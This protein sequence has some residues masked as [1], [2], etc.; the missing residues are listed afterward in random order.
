MAALTL[1]IADKAHTLGVLT[2]LID[3]GAAITETGVEF[4]SGDKLTIT[5]L[6]KYD[7]ISL[8]TSGAASGDVQLVGTDIQ[9]H[10]GTGF[11]KIGTLDRA[12]DGTLIIEFVNTYLGT[13]VT[14][15][16]VEK[17]MQNLTIAADTS[18][19]I[20][21][22]R[23][24]TFTLSGSNTGSDTST[25]TIAGTTGAD[26]IIYSTNAATLSWTDGNAADGDILKVLVDQTVT[27]S[28]IDM[29]ATAY[30]VLEA[31]THN[32]ALTVTVGANNT[33]ITT[34][35]ANDIIK[36]SAAADLDT[37]IN[38]GLGVDTLELTNAGAITV[39]FGA[40][41]GT[42]ANIEKLQLAN[43]A[44]T[45]TLD[46]AD[47][48]KEI[49]GG[50]AVDIIDASDRAVTGAGTGQYDLKISTGAGADVVT[51]SKG[52][53]NIDLGTDDNELIITL[54]TD[55]TKDDV[56]T[57]AGAADKI[58]LDDAITTMTDEQFTGVT[59]FEELV[60]GTGAT[61]LTL[62]DQVREA[63]I[64]KVTGNAASHVVTGMLTVD[65]VGMTA[66]VGMTVLSG[67]GGVTIVTRADHVTTADTF[68]GDATV[69][70]DILR[71]ATSGTIDAADL[72]NVSNIETLDI[73]ATSGNVSVTI[74]EANNFKTISSTGSTGH[75][76]INTVAE[77]NVV[78]G[79]TINTGIGNDTITTGATT[80]GV[81][82]NAG[83]GDNI[84]TVGVATN[85]ITAGTGDDIVNLVAGTDTLKLG[86]GENIV[87]VAYANFTTADTIHYGDV[88]GSTVID[89]A[90][91]TAGIAAG[92]KNILNF[93]DKITDDGVAD[94]DGDQVEEKLAATGN[95]ID[96]IK[97][98]I[99]DTQIVTLG[100]NALAS[101]VI[102]VDGSL[103]TTNTNTL[104]V[105][106]TAMDPTSGTFTVKGGAGNDVVK[107]DFASVTSTTSLQMGGEAASG[108]DT[109]QIA[110][111]T[112]TGAT[113]EDADFTLST[114]LEKL[115]FAV[116]G[117][118][119]IT[120]GDKAINA[121]VRT[122]D[123]SMTVEAV[124]VAQL[125]ASTIDLSTATVDADFTI[126]MG[127][128]AD[129]IK[130]KA[131]HLTATDT[132]DGGL[133]SDTL[134]FVGASVLVDADFAGLTSVEKLKLG[135]GN[136][137]SLVYATNMQTAGI[138]LIDGSLVGAG[139]SVS[140]DLSAAT[141]GID[142][143]LSSGNDT[144]IMG[145]SALT[146]DLGDGNNTVQTDSAYLT[147]GDKI[148]GGTG[149]D[150]L[151]ITD[152]ATI[153]DLDFNQITN[154]EKLVL[155]DDVNSVELGAKAK[156][157]GVVTIDGS[158]STDVLTATVTD[159]GFNITGG[160][161]ADIIKID[162]ANLSSLTF[163]GMGGT[164]VIELTS[165][166]NLNDS[167]FA[168]LSQIETL[169]LNDFNTTQSITLGS[170]SVTADDAT[171]SGLTTI[172]ASG[173]LGVNNVEVD[174][175]GMLKNM[176]VTT[177][178]GNDIITM[179]RGVDT[180][181]TGLG[182][183]IIKV[184]SENFT[185]ADTIN[186]GG[187]TGAGGILGDILEITTTTNA[188]TD[189]H[190][191]N[192]LG[193]ET[194]KLSSASGTYDITLG[195]TEA[196]ANGIREIAIA[197]GVSAN[198]DLSTITGG[199]IKITKIGTTGNVTVTTSTTNQ[200][201]N[202]V[203]GNGA[204]TVKI[205][206][207]NLTNADTY[208]FGAGAD[209]LELT[210]AATVIDADFAN[211]TGVETV[212]VGNFANSITIGDTASTTG[213]VTTVDL[214][215]VTT[216]TNA[217]TVD[218]STMLNNVG[219]TVT[220]GAGVDTIKM[221]AE[222]LTTADHLI[223][224]GSTDI[225]QFTTL[226]VG[227]TDTDF[228]NVT[229][230]ETLKLV[231]G[232]TGDTQSLSL[233]TQAFDG[234]N[235]LKTI[236]GSSVAG[237]LTV[238]LT[239][240]SDV[241]ITG[242]KVD[243]TNDGTTTTPRDI[244]INDVVYDQPNDLYYKAKVANGTANLT[245]EDFT[246]GANWE[247][248][249]FTPELV[250]TMD[251]AYLTSADTI[252]GG[253]STTDKIIFDTAAT[254]VGATA[255]TGVSGIE[256]LELKATS[257][258]QS[259]TLGGSGITTVDATLAGAAVTIDGATTTGINLS[260]VITNT[261]NDTLKI[262]AGDLDAGDIFT[263][264]SG[265]NTLEITTDATNTITDSDFAN[266]TGINTLKLSKDVTGQT[267]TLANTAITAGV[268]KVDL[269]S[270]TSAS[271]S[272]VDLSTMTTENV[273]FT[274]LGGSGA[275][276]I[277]M[278]AAQLASTDVLT[279][280]GGTDTLEFT[281]IADGM[282][283]TQFTGVTGIDTLK[284]A[285][286][287]GQ[288]ITLGTKALEVGNIRTIDGSNLTGINT[289]TISD[290][291]TNHG[292]T[293]TTG[294]G[295]DTIVM[296]AEDLTSS[297]TINGNGGTDTLS[298]SA[299]GAD[300]TIG[301]A[302][303]T[304][305]SNVEILKLQ[306]SGSFTQ[307]VTLGGGFTTVDAS[308]ATD[309][310]TIDGYTTTALN[311]ASV[312]TGTGADTLKIKAADL[313]A[314]DVFA[315]GTG[316]DT[317]QIMTD[318][319]SLITDAKFTNKTE[320]DTLK[321]GNFTGQTL[322]IGD[323]AVTAGI[324][325]IDL[326]GITSSGN[327]STV[328]M[329]TNMNLAKDMIVLGGA[330]ADT[331]QMKTEHLTLSDT[332]TGNGGDDVLELTTVATNVTDA[333]FTEVTGIETLKLG[334]FTNQSLTLGNEALGGGIRI[335]N[336]TALD[337][338]NGVSI[339]MSGATNDYA[340]TINTGT[341][342]GAD[343]V[344]MKAEHL[345]SADTIA[346]G[347]GTADKLTLTT[348]TG[349]LGASSFGNI[350]G[351]EV[352]ELTATTGAQNITL[353]GDF[354]TVDAHTTDTAITIDGAT[355][356][357]L[358]LSNVTTGS[359]NDTLKIQAS[360]FTKD[361]AGTGGVDESDIFA[362][363]DGA[364]TL[365]LVGA[366]TITD[367]QFKKVT[368][369]E[370]VT[371]LANATGQSV[372]LGDLSVAAGL[373]KVDFSAITNTTFGVTV[374]LDDITSDSTS[375]II[376][377]AGADSIIMNASHLTIADTLTG[378]GNGSGV[379]TLTLVGA[380]TLLDADFTNVS[381]I[382]KLVLANADGQTLQLG[383]EALGGGITTVDG[384]ALSLH[385]VAIDMSGASLN[386]D[387]TITT[388]TGADTITMLA[389]HLTSADTLNGGTGVAVDTLAFTDA[390]N[391][392]ADKF[393]HVTNMEKI[394]LQATT[395][396]QDIA[397]VSGFNTVDASVATDSVTID[398]SL[399]GD[400]N[401]T[402]TTGTDND[403][404]KLT[405]TTLDTNDTI[406]G[407]STSDT[408]T[409]EIIA[410]G[411]TD[412][413]ASTLDNE[414]TD[415]KIAHVTNVE[416]I[417]LTNSLDAVN[418]TLGSN[419]STN[420]INK[421]DASAT[422][423]VN[424]IDLS[425]MTTNVEVTGGTGSDII[426]ASIGDNVINAGYGNDTVTINAGNLDASDIIDG[427]DGIDE[428]ILTGLTTDTAT[429]AGITGFESI[430]LADGV[431]QE[432]ILGAAEDLNNLLKVDA[433]NVTTGNAITVDITGYEIVT[434]VDNFTYVGGAGDD[435]FKMQSTHLTK[436]DVLSGGFIDVNTDGIDDSTDILEFTDVAI[437]S[438]SIDIFNNVS[439]FET[440]KLADVAS[441]QLVT[442]KDGV[443]TTVTAAGNTSTDA[444]T[445]NAGN[446]TGNL[447]I[448]TVGGADIIT[449]AKG[450]NTISSG[451]GADTI[452]FNI[453]TFTSADVI[454]G[455]DDT[456][457]I[458]FID[459]SVSGA[460][461]LTDAAFAGGNKTNI[462]KIK[463]SVNEAGQSI[464]LGTDATS[465]GINEIDT[466]T[467]LQTVTIDAGALGNNLT[468]NTN[469]GND[470]ITGGM[471]VN[472][473]NSGSGNDTIKIAAA[474]LT[475]VDTIDGDAGTLDTLELTGATT[476]DDSA[477]TAISNVEILKLANVTGQTLVLGTEAF[478]AGFKTIDSSNLATNNTASINLVGFTQDTK[479]IGGAGDETVTMV[480]STLNGSDDIDLGAG[481]DTII[482][483]DVLST[484]NLSKLKGVETIQLADGNN[485]TIT[486]V[487]TINSSL[488]ID[489]T[490]L[491]DVNKVT[492]DGSALGT[493][494]TTFIVNSSTGAD[495]ITLGGST[496][497]VDAD[498]GDDIVNITMAHLSDANVDTI[499]GGTGTN[500]LKLTAGG[501]ATDANLLNI[502]NIAE[503]TLTG[504]TTDYALTLG[505]NAGNNNIININGSALTTGKVSIDASTL[506]TEN[507]T[508]KG[509][510]ANDTFII[511]A[512]QLD[513]SDTIN[514]KSTTDVDTLT[515]KGDGTADTTIINT[516]FTNITN[517]EK[518]TYGE[519]A[520][521]TL[522][523]GDKFKD[524]GIKIIDAS[525]VASDK[526]FTFNA[527]TMTADVAFDIT[528]GAGIDTITMNG[529]H[530]TSSDVLK[531][532]TGANVLQLSGTATGADKITDADFAA[533]STGV[534]TIK[535]TENLAQDIT[536]GVNAVDGG[537]KTIDASGLGSA[538]ATINTSAV[539]SNMTI[540]AGGGNDTITIGGGNVT[541]TAGNGDDIINTT[542]ANLTKDD[543]INGG[544]QNTK[545]ILNISD[546]ANGLSDV[547]FTNISN[548]E[549]LT[550]TATTAQTITL[551]DKFKAA[552]FDTIDASLVSS[553]VTVDLSSMTTDGNFTITGGASNDTI[554]ML[555]SHI[556]SGDRIDLGAGTTDTME[557]SSL[558]QSTTNIT[559]ASFTNI[560][561][562]DIL[563][564][565]NYSN[566]VEFGDTM[567][568]AGVK[569]IDGS[570]N[571]SYGYGL[572]IN[573]TNMS[574]S[575]TTAIGGYTLKGGAGDDYFKLRADQ[576]SSS[577]TI[578]GGS[579]GTSVG[580][581][582][583]FVN[584][585]IFTD[586]TKFTGVSNIDKILLG[587]FAGQQI[588]LRDGLTSVLD[589]HTLS[590]TNGITVGG[591]TLTT[592]IN[593]KTGA[594]D[595]IITL[596]S[597]ADTATLGAGDDTLTIVTNNIDGNDTIDFGDGTDNLILTTA[598]DL[599]DS[600]FAKISNLETITLGNFANSLT[601]A[602]YAKAS[603][604]TKIDN[605][606]SGSATTIDMSSMSSNIGLNYLGGT[607][608]D[609]IKMV[610]TQFD[611]DD[612][613]DGGSGTDIL[614]LTNSSYIGD[615]AFT[616]VK[617][618]ETLKLGAGV[619]N[620]TLGA[621][622][623]AAGIT[624][625]DTSAITTEALTID[626]TG[627]SGN[628]TITGHD[629]ADIITIGQ[630]NN[631]INAGLGDDTI[632]AVVANL[633]TADVIDGQGGTNDSLVLT[634]AI[635][636]TTTAKFTQVTNVENLVLGNF[637][638]QELTLAVTNN[639]TK[640]DGS[641]LT[642]T[643]NVKVN[644][645]AVTSDLNVVTSGGNDTIMLGDTATS[646][647]TISAGNGDDIIQFTSSSVITSANDVV[648]GGL[649]N[650]TLQFTSTSA[651]ST[652]IDTWFGTHITG[653]ETI[654]FGNITGNSI[655]YGA[656][657][658]T[659]GIRTIDT[660]SVATTLT[661]TI[662]LSAA[663]YDMTVN[664]GAGIDLV[665]AG[666]KIDTL[667]L[668]AGEDKVTFATSTLLTS[669]DTINGGDDSDTIV[670]TAT[671]TIADVAF[672]N[673]TNVEK[674][675]LLGT[676]AKTV[677]IGTFAKNSGLNE[678]DASTTDGTTIG[679]AV[680]TIDGQ[681]FSGNIS[682]KTG[683][684]KDVI[685][686]GSGNVTID[687]KD[688]DDLIKVE[689]STFDT[690]DSIDAGA[691]TDTV[692]FIDA[693]HLTNDMIGQITNAEIIKFSDGSNQSAQIGEN[694][695]TKNILKYD[696]SLITTGKSISM[697][698]S[699]MTT[700]KDMTLIGGQGDDTFTFKKAQ[701]TA[702]DVVTAG[703]GIDK[704]VF[705][706]EVSGAGFDDLFANKT[707]L[708]TIAL[709][710]GFNHTLT[711]GAKAQTAGVNQIDA[712]ALN[713]AF[714]INVDAS[715][716]TKTLSVVSNGGADV[717]VAGSG[718]DSYVLGNG[719]DKITFKS[720][721][722]V[723]D[724]VH[725]GNG[726]D[727]IYISDLAKITDV[728]LENVE[729]FEKM[730]LSN[731]A[732]A[733]SIV[734][735]ANAQAGGLVELDGSAMGTIG[736]GSTSTI[737]I[738]AMSVDFTLKTGAGIDKIVLGGGDV[739]VESGTGADEITITAANLTLDDRINGGGDSDK[740]IIST[741][742]SG[743]SAIIDEDFTN[744]T[745]V[746]TLVL[747][748]FDGQKVTIGTLAKNAGINTIDA[749][750]LSS[751]SNNLEIDATS[752]NTAN[753]TITSGSG[754]DM[755][756][757][758]TANDTVDAGS[759]DD[760]IV[761]RN[762]DFTVGD[763]IIGNGGIDTI[764][765]SDAATII[766]EDFTNVTTV[767]T[768]KL[769]DGASQTVTLGAKA[770]SAVL[771]EL[772]ATALGASNGVTVDVGSV[773]ST[774]SVK[775][776]AGDD[777]F[778]ITS[779][780]L[781]T[782][783]SIDGGANVALNATHFGDKVIIEDKATVT[784]DKFTYFKNIETITLSDFIGQ[785]LVLGAKA[786]TI[787]LKNIDASALTVN[788]G[789]TID[790]KDLVADVALTG[791]AGS[792]TVTISMANTTSA[793]SID[794][795]DGANDTLIIADAINA[796]TTGGTFES[797][798]DAG[799][800]I[801]LSGIE[802]LK[803]L[804]TS[805]GQ[806]LTLGATAKTLGLNKVDLTAV[807]ASSGVVVDATLLATA[808]TLTATSGNHTITTATGAYNDNITSGSGINTIIL[809][810][811]DDTVDAGSGEDT[812]Q[813]ASANLTSADSIDGGIGVK[814]TL[815]VSN[816]ASNM[817]DDQFT[818]VK[819]LEVVKL[820][821][822]QS[823]QKITLGSFAKTAGINTVDG[824]ALNTTNGFE[825]NAATFAGN[826]TVLGGAWD[827]TF[828]GGQGND[829]ANMGAGDDTLKYSTSYL[830]S[831]D[832]LD[833]G[834]GTDTLII[835][836]T[837]DLKD[838]QFT[839]LSSI[840]T[841][842]LGANLTGQEVI[843]GSLA[844][845]SGI[846]TLDLRGIDGAN[847]TV[848][849]S[850]FTKD[851]EILV[852]TAGGKF[853]TSSK[854]D[855]V[856]IEADMFTE[857]L[858]Y[859]GGLGIDTIKISTP[860]TTAIVDLDFTKLVGVEVL[861]L[862]SGGTVNLG[863]KAILAGITTVDL[864]LN[865]TAA[866]TIIATDFAKSLNITL[867]QNQTET[868]TTHQSVYVNDFVST[869]SAN[870]GAL[871]TINL[872]TGNSDTI[873]ITDE[874]HL[875]STQLSAN[876]TNIEILKLGTVGNH[877]VN[878]NGSNSSI[879][880]L[881]GT[882]MTA[883][884]S[885]IINVTGKTEA[886]EVKMGAG[887]DT[888]VMSLADLAKY[889]VAGDATTPGTA[890]AQKV[891]DGGAGIDTLMISDAA[892]ITDTMFDDPNLTLLGTV[893]LTGIE[894]IGLKA[895]GSITLGK[896]ASVEGI[897]TVDVSGSTGN[898]TILTTAVTKNVI[899]NL[900]ANDD[901]VTT[902]GKN[903]TVN[904]AAANLTSADA[905][906]LGAGTDTLNITTAISTSN[907]DF[908]GITNVEILKLS[909]DTAGQAVV[910]TGTSFIELDAKLMKT[911]NVTVDA[912]D[913]VDRITISLG[914]GDDTVIMDSD[915]L[916]NADMKAING[917]AGNDILNISG[918]ATLV[919]DNFTTRK[920]SGF[921]TIKLTGSLVAE[922]NFNA[923]G[924]SK[925]IAD[926]AG[927]TFNSSI[928]T[929]NFDVT[930]SVATD[931]ITLGKGADII[932][933]VD[934]NDVIIAGLGND[935]FYFEGDKLDASDKVDGGDADALTLGNDGVDTII[936]NSTIGTFADANMTQ[937]VSIETL[938]FG[939][940]AGQTYTYG[941]KTTA[942]G[943]TT[944]DASLAASGFTLDSSSLTSD[945]T[946]SFIGGAGV[947]TV[948]T[949]MAY[950]TLTD[951]IDGA[952]GN[953]ILQISDAGTLNDAQFTGVKNVET[954]KLADGANILNLGSKFSNSGILTID[955]SLVTTNTN[956]NTI[957]MSIVTTK[958]YS[959]IGGAGDDTIKMKS[960]L[961]NSGI[962]L[963]AGGQAA[964]GADI[965]EITDK[966]I[967]ADAAFTN[968][969]SLETIKVSNYAGNSIVLGEKARLAGVVEVDGSAMT[970]GTID[971]D[972][973]TMTTDIDVTLNGGAKND[974]F[975]FNI[976][977]L[978]ATD[979]I[980]GGGTTDVDTIVI[981]GSGTAL[982][983]ADFTLVTNVEKLSFVA[984]SDYTVTLNSNSTTLA[985]TAGIVTVDAVT[986]GSGD[987][988][989]L[990]ASYYTVGLT[991]TS[992]AGDDIITTGSGDDKVVAGDGNDIITSGS[993]VDNLSGGNGDDTFVFTFANLTSADK[994]AG[995][996]G[997][998]TMQFTDAVTFNAAYG[999]F[1000]NKT[1001]IEKLQLDGGGEAT[1002]NIYMVN[1003]G[1004]REIDGSLSGATEHLTIN[1005]SYASNSQNL[1006]LK[1007]GAGDDKIYAGKGTDTLTGGAGADTFIFSGVLKAN[1008]T[1009]TIT[1010]FTDGTD[1011][1012]S[1013]SFA[1014]GSLDYADAAR[1015]D[1016][1017]QLTFSDFNNY[1018]EDVT[1019]DK[1020]DTDNNG[1021]LDG[1022]YA[1023]ITLTGGD[1024]ISLL[1025][1026]AS[1027][1028]TQA[1029]F[1030]YQLV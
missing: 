255:F 819:N 921:E 778:K 1020:Y 920:I 973:T 282:I 358:D 187:Q 490:A 348:A 394:T 293:I 342:T 181:S 126:T 449:A 784:D 38:G 487:D 281:T 15:L 838:V 134:E 29:S 48:F 904:V 542:Y 104:T 276:T 236:D 827:D 460:N 203:F 740:L 27:G 91:I 64:V 50:S 265:I 464:T 378:G 182:D 140:V 196:Y 705:V 90:D 453:A 60:A 1002:M 318:A 524:S 674:L 259:V 873:I 830:N 750:L 309:D 398:A 410:A 383:D 278:V 501:T 584:S 26:T 987:V 628:I 842:K 231:A 110:D 470:I 280:N 4:A 62:G 844:A 47:S 651:A 693:V 321:V 492:V 512:S 687:S 523:A 329:S 324:K 52:K 616:N 886:I 169:E 128:G 876:L 813:I 968:F 796:A 23:T 220:G 269:T 307:N 106:L 560:L 995:D 31:S 114:G 860:A 406:D 582:L 773:T 910:L 24:L 806:T 972:M 294:S 107:M 614:W 795:G 277:K 810:G 468:I 696:A 248:I 420:G 233:G 434:D 762:T 88:D 450:V 572:T 698:L 770:T 442:I 69:T 727:T 612:T 831:S 782:K 1006:T 980:N 292:L 997:T 143:I 387:V 67:T 661:S 960:V 519:S 156:A 504:A 295:A 184:S 208:T 834:A 615:S 734:F 646:K 500:T 970:T 901:S 599:I 757:L 938:K 787:G 275:D 647:A 33:D 1030:V 151:E 234:G 465:A 353:A 121:G 1012:I 130:T 747:S 345:T 381:G 993:G 55:L 768:L 850:A 736:T 217:Q 108:F 223:G 818:N 124:P 682:I 163:N 991:V 986:L 258:V 741:S 549:K 597:G 900:G 743:T 399:N 471:G 618:V 221:K 100:A 205:L 579:N 392:T 833:G 488:T 1016:G 327:S 493:A 366:A 365:E 930:G 943:V 852:D 589:A 600:D 287:G 799:N 65:M 25:Y 609:T 41:T 619:H 552:G 320:I 729:S 138:G 388:G 12:S 112:T 800:G 116:D 495:E 711:L 476:L 700:D 135:D 32:K 229:G 3:L 533:T 673:I 260:K 310:V 34:G 1014:T 933:G 232:G 880:M 815:L 701:F 994:V 670:M 212:K 570:M 271:S 845:K 677:T 371:M 592:A 68:T 391:L 35:T 538:T 253:I 992:G 996:N 92:A 625:I 846:T 131:V 484:P 971:V 338:T 950:L 7:T 494:T 965:L 805:G 786:S 967:I 469:S 8:K 482:F 18:G 882:L 550:L 113:L 372:T 176:T 720:G 419:A 522:T 201:D 414:I 6:T 226:A 211:I 339:D 756:K 733:T 602:D 976:D 70:T 304:N 947:D 498:G 416:V 862:S 543:S 594:G 837:A 867:G 760:T 598:A 697:D 261:G 514:G 447:T 423:S 716:Y 150:I 347:G 263:L 962:T 344:K 127:K 905:I 506:G 766:D 139:N 313:D 274:V 28:A 583:E 72:T 917:G 678:I 924:I 149:T 111:G 792:D 603:G 148:T 633:T 663:A 761:F 534:E 765:I 216:N 96:V 953:D 1019:Y 606:L 218:L 715:A 934:G 604:L 690:S 893:K 676:G 361:D 199:A 562:V 250:V 165:A 509:G 264:G 722:L 707:A 642:G 692:Q 53:D 257:G 76:T 535:F 879:S 322:D 193:I 463:L 125:L 424:T 299:N 866:S 659:S 521:H 781:T 239:V 660:T 957:D 477:F 714:S 95:K 645:S 918:S 86:I 587:N 753:F 540:K 386:N 433:T 360:D 791:G 459:T 429:F 71:V 801:G 764:L 20:A 913:I 439:G 789:V 354:T 202:F 823:G 680:V 331:I 206:T 333:Q 328:D 754:Y 256:I 194:I 908:T 425:A 577:D 629:G 699:S 401:L 374:H 578:N 252:T 780:K 346:L 39:D 147:I 454:N 97:L 644:A 146:I 735:G 771:K 63:G 99:D 136:N 832:A 881:D 380:A 623:E 607:G 847:Y 370:N 937:V 826:L 613:I 744:V 157:A 341:G 563:K 87:N 457:T 637:N 144:V 851:L 526:T 325:T 209:T 101:K 43:Q 556:T 568:V 192:V 296:K 969:T 864:S 249:A 168:N 167:D 906:A 289:I 227:K 445:I 622:A 548:M 718:L 467:V 170:S 518:L 732:G 895:G 171:N 350:T 180:I 624:T 946:F 912:T 590:S 649:G 268:N 731:T 872:G 120:L 726:A 928:L 755:I 915:D 982:A 984:G 80:T 685:T 396:A 273:N 204:D 591:A 486:L 952:G 536:V 1023:L 2:D 841:L 899:V 174:I 363:G 632:K 923:T 887:A 74:G 537:L 319:G 173:L 871:D 159:T 79:L 669:A 684:A 16:I 185:S 593:I 706:D 9:Y 525:I 373:T 638:N 251:S 408:D 66:D 617:N 555:G 775:G 291:A 531:L 17:V 479:I 158:A 22:P 437:N 183:D 752:L 190:F 228:T 54:A 520:K 949:K 959:I 466:M 210:D 336:A 545:D 870:L 931:T 627:T 315:M 1029:D 485:Q 364:D 657:A 122:I 814:D 675:Q 317:L 356:V 483:T 717:I 405:A 153:V 975:K 267:V 790:M 191:T 45:I 516:D 219:F 648:D 896:N 848:N 551:G 855:T 160:T 390:A 451:A 46:T 804:N 44:N 988:L 955:A 1001:G 132:I 164:D 428:L 640:V 102:E 728:S 544:G 567:Q 559:D 878:F 989:T 472:T 404:I 822:N 798:L 689:G 643:N 455:G 558:S 511:A 109:L 105:D 1027:G 655:T 883:A 475:S 300:T 767:E 774:F 704:V 503:V 1013:L 297:D 436:D 241:T 384:S 197:D 98:G 461:A 214:S 686:I 142:L 284:L 738:S 272:T 898:S 999:E 456:D 49:I 907:A 440:L 902:G 927:L 1021:T 375:K 407:G 357:A 759:G 666:T 517:M 352:L 758:G 343:T 829:I 117:T 489:A 286:L 497:T 244:S 448:N 793:D 515:I 397:L 985:Q 118:H 843:L 532:G 306:E 1007:G 939:N 444:L 859:T 849:T 1000:Y 389:A 499:D 653:I 422:A 580:D 679:T 240:A 977:Q 1017:T 417:K 224:G 195:Q 400:T 243:Y 340:M 948:K 983:D 748:K 809:D 963:Q 415:T 739:T 874:A 958:A 586:A 541:V 742:A 875:T 474:T 513:L 262:E 998:D 891:I 200:A 839:K 376:A 966:A 225:L 162:S 510:D 911:G 94:A 664:G 817:I 382:E 914:S 922:T 435:T 610:G 840:E 630:G 155:A 82:I 1009:N 721:Y 861:S 868:I 478:G 634:T 990:D 539:S 825:I 368:G 979:T 254:S 816:I 230:M 5:G 1:A 332:L 889:S 84:I 710:N 794:L 288:S 585:V 93:T 413:T 491:I 569:T 385:T 480:A 745:S 763:T 546:S 10:N 554:K 85:G 14:D 222:D 438:S 808:L 362:F 725:G 856:T 961:A 821:T 1025:G 936:F 723:K 238:D 620:V 242:G 746:E 355:T 566:S 564:F 635:N 1026:V 954:L 334:N 708:E 719:D 903:D 888:I 709:S 530:L 213:G 964:A 349:T 702:N 713:D 1015:V 441:A 858:D 528:G 926:T 662:D 785:S 207:A 857:F 290:T 945:V 172:D 303:F 854:N 865:S 141:V 175:S 312:T 574:T 377:G 916:V 769:S 978:T 402:I 588:V 137:Q 1008:G 75:N 581:T 145:D 803:L 621:L 802:T 811:G 828:T 932:R 179:G 123:T 820:A 1024:T 919:D 496:N 601:L 418:V 73:T 605:S 305:V 302:A 337:S 1010:D 688:G 411:A 502:T 189:A 505:T 877:D 1018:V 835:T 279:G 892:T 565:T 426:K 245:T 956:T 379:D 51:I 691:G 37:N 446:V 665:K 681:G 215:G 885:S 481:D 547:T 393:D 1005:G 154:F 529:T 58:T 301:V 863:T 940:Y 266:K 298:L 783:L 981:S 403:T 166:A 412:G 671:T 836:D 335:V 557:I 777:T 1011:K 61:T 694:T 427:G 57:A 246:I 11:V 237:K 575:N 77:T 608:A 129:T 772:D 695:V 430:K 974:T 724:I 527:S 19:T 452:K 576:I 650:D 779:E 941:D 807:T 668:G 409:L 89:A 458:E 40:V 611:S 152:A 626:L 56:I 909:S 36:V 925:V 951:T 235:G 359:G 283:D 788:N 749:K 270:L 395:G 683:N 462:E 776:G 639:F 890:A 133:G 326:T 247:E 884:Q 797:W 308:V 188:I 869:T 178:A 853:I 944:L 812:I 42:I 78:G 596:G 316:T 351:V 658:A 652:I 323:K 198:I 929:K 177:A 285:A 431:T 595:D 30:N 330:G 553:G 654:K 421:I 161:A 1022:D 314:S 115:T 21:D 1004:V 712:T 311:L 672:T 824:T 186:G 13:P 667:N 730:V 1028:I 935:T 443:F 83:N 751:A 737:D 636:E 103:I 703:S 631:T 656:K 894:A 367:A 369:L 573:M 508:F 897:T 561:G 59:G 641:K 432:I 119:S 81:T 571:S 942:A 473:I 1003:A 507:V